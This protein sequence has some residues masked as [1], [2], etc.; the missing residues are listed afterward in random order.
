[1]GRRRG[2]SLLRGNGHEDSGAAE[3][4]NHRENMLA[5]TKMVMAEPQWKLLSMLTESGKRLVN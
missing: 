4:G 1:M 5:P 2:A 3:L